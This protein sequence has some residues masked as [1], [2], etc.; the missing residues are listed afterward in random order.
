M[1]LDISD[2]QKVTTALLLLTPGA[3]IIYIRSFFTTGR[4]KT[5]TEEFLT[6]LFLS[7]IYFAA[8]F[9]LYQSTL[10][11]ECLKGYDTIIWFAY[12]FMLPAAFGIIFGLNVQR[13]WMYGLLEKFGLHTVHTLPTAWDWK[14][15]KG[16]DHFVII[17][18][19]SGSVF[20]GYYGT[21]SFSSSDGER[22]IFLE[23]VYK[24]PDKESEWQQQGS[25]LWLPISEVESIEFIEKTK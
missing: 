7:L 9:K 14:F 24:Q 3:I 2:P 10:E 17:T 6:Y 25:S 19:K 18:T 21:N 12:V 5:H 11:A 20:R 23:S 16:T 15:S 22:D 4:R 1:E 8:T 13:N